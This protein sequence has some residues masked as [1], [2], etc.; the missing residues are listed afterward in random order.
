M[1]LVD[2][3]GARLV[4]GADVWG[5]PAADAERVLALYE[6]PAPTALVITK[7]DETLQIGGAL[8]AALPRPAGPEWHRHRLQG[9][10]HRNA[11]ACGADEGACAQPCIGSEQGG[12]A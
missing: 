9:P 4:D 5:L 8:H 7:L 3:A 10:E 2:G 6:D 1:L 12:G 11:R